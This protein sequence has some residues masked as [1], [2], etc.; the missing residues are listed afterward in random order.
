MKDSLRA[1]KARGTGLNELVP[2]VKAEFDDRVTMD[3]I[4]KA[5]LMIGFPLGEVAAVMS[6]NAYQPC[7]IVQLM[8]GQDS[9]PD[10]AD[11]GLAIASFTEG[12][13]ADKAEAAFGTIKEELSLDDD[14]EELLA[15]PGKLGCSQAEAAGIVYRGTDFG[16]ADVL[17]NLNLLG[18]PDVIAQVAKDLDQDISSNEDYKVIRDAD[19]IEFEDAVRILKACGSDA[20]D[21]IVSENDYSGF[22]DSEESVKDI[23]SAL[24]PAGF[25]NEEIM[26]GIVEADVLGDNE[27]GAIVSVALEMGIPVGDITSFLKSEQVDADTLDDEL[28]DIDT[29]ILT[30]IDFLHTFLHADDKP[31]PEEVVQASDPASESEKS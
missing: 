2:G 10:V 28:R 24:S 7:E 25:S 26:G 29:N 6:A 31:A 14:N 22:E 8:D 13:T 15:L 23:F 30:R 17:V 11:I 1:G 3:E 5:A 21:C 27:K 18:L 4:F 16:F 12:T 9:S 19:N 20:G